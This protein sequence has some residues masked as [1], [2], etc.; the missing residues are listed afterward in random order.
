[1]I[2]LFYG[3]REFLKGTSKFYIYY[4]IKNFSRQFDASSSLHFE[5]GKNTLSKKKTKIP[6]VINDEKILQALGISVPYYF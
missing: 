1:M 6:V 3:I 5:N 4:L 2:K